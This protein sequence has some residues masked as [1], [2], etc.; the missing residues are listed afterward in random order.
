MSNTIKFK[1][2][3]TSLR[4]GIYNNYTKGHTASVETELNQSTN[5]K[6]WRH[7]IYQ[8]KKYKCRLND[9]NIPEGL[10]DAC[11]KSE[12]NKTK[13][14]DIFVFKNI[15]VN[16]VKLDVDSSF[17]MYIKEEISETA[18]ILNAKSNTNTHL[19]RQMIH[20]PISFDYR[21][22]GLNINNRD[23]LERIMKSNGNYAFVVKGFIYD[24]DNDTLNFLITLVGPNGILQT[25]VFKE[26]KGVGQKLKISDDLVFDE[27]V[28]VT[29]KQN[30][31]TGKTDV[32]IEQVNR[33]RSK[34]G[35]IGENYIYELLKDKLLEDSDLFHTSKLY[36]FSPYD[37]EYLENGIK[38]YVEV[39]STQSDKEIFNLSS[40]ELKFMEEHK[41]NYYLYMVTNVKS[42]FPKYNVYT[43][44]DIKKMKMVATNYRVTI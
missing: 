10:I 16:G 9:K 14:T 31:S 41:E 25:S 19:G 1:I 39:K 36:K 20:Y 43:Y 42:E 18:N 30:L 27:N 44:Y 3:E 11:K 21:K 28:I 40:G 26:G 4:Y 17:C 22:D 13:V 12:K 37:I 7:D 29:C 35:E 2:S 38:K 15:F 5:P 6:K 23:I 34:N 33:V 8:L 32:E 24:I